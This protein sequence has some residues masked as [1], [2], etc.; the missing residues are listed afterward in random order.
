M[1]M[2]VYHLA[3]RVMV[4]QADHLTDALYRTV[5]DGHGAG[6][7]N[8]RMRSIQDCLPLMQVYGML[9]QK[10]QEWMLDKSRNL[11]RLPALVMVMYAMLN[12]LLMT[13]HTL[14]ALNQTGLDLC[15]VTEHD[16]GLITGYG[17]LQVI[18]KALYIQMLNIQKVTSLNGGCLPS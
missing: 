7:R 3:F 9:L 10:L 1:H 15:G 11:A 4:Q 12:S 5:L 16:T 13:D 8:C 17:E 6:I 2:V 18:S 14:S